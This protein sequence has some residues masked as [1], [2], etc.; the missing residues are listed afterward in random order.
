MKESKKIL[1]FCSILYLLLTTFRVSN[2]NSIT[3]I[4]YILDFG[5]ITLHSYSKRFKF[6]ILLKPKTFLREPQQRA[7]V[8]RFNLFL[9]YFVPVICISLHAVYLVTSR[10]N[11]LIGVILHF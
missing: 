4:G 9:M 8:F 7:H 3:G 11:A 1:Y 5:F 2:T 6:S 10:K